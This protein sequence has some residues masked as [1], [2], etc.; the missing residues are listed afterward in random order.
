MLSDPK[1]P[2]RLDIVYAD[3]LN[4]IIIIKSPLRPPYAT[5][6]KCYLIR[7]HE[8][9]GT[10]NHPKTITKHPPQVHTTVETA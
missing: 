4:I 3:Y 10:I 9:T 8:T 7:L 6:T 1:Q 2:R 5:G